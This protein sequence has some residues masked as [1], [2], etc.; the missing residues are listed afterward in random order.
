MNTH[1][2]THSDRGQPEISIWDLSC[3]TWTMSLSSVIMAVFI[4]SDYPTELGAS[5]GVVWRWKHTTFER[6]RLTEKKRSIA[7]WLEI[8]NP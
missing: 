3:Q 4:F 6:S 8:A 7:H 5:R 2:H 1:T